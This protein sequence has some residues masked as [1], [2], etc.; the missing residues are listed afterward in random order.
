MQKHTIDTFSVR[1]TSELPAL[2]ELEDI[3][4]FTI[5]SLDNAS[6]EN[7]ETTCICEK[8][9]EPNQFQI[10]SGCIRT[11]A[12]IIVKYDGEQYPTLVVHDTR[13]ERTVLDNHF[14]VV[15]HPEDDHAYM[16]RMTSIHDHGYIEASF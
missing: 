14:I 12:G 3:T 13:L 7:H 16:L 10:V 6:P 5:I 15:Q 8:L 1:A 11:S 9:D 4:Q 2:W